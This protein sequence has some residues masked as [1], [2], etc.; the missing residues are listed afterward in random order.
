MASPGVSR[1]TSGD[2]VI[3]AIIGGEWSL[4]TA[5]GTQQGL[6]NERR[7]PLFHVKHY[8]RTKGFLTRAS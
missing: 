1:E 3:R 6:A 2:T 4:S 5:Q 8:G 7:E